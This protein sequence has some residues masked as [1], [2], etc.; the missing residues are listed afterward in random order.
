MHLPLFAG[1]KLILRIPEE[2]THYGPCLH[3]ETL[4]SQLLVGTPV[5]S[6][7]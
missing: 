3:E 7:F 2:A 4:P 5:F 6:M 1:L